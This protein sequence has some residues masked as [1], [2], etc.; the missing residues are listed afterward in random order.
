LVIVSYSKELIIALG[1]INLPKKSQR[2]LFARKKES[3]AKEAPRR[4]PGI[5]GWQRTEP[6]TSRFNEL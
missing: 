3:Q 2:N 4:M 5:P 1:T 6:K